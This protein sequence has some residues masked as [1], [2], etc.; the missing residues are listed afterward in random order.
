MDGRRELDG[1]SQGGQG[2]RWP[3][4]PPGTAR[5]E[6]GL[7]R[8]RMDRARPGT[9]RL[10]GRAVLP[11]V[12]RSR[13]KH[14][15]TGLFRVVPAQKARCL[16]RARA[17]RRPHSRIEL[18]DAVAPP[19]TPARRPT[20]PPPIHARRGAEPRRAW[21]PQEGALCRCRPPRRAWQSCPQAPPADATTPAL[22][23]NGSVEELASS[24]EW[25]GSGAGERRGEEEGERRAGTERR[26]ARSVAAVQES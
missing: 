23:T 26:G 13:P 7:A 11:A 8:A 9:N 10:T 21:W 14:E 19:A 22:A 17:V 2:Y 3:F 15:P 25:S 18:A 20:P 6:P 12:P 16:H 1:S 24:V 5:P 4:G